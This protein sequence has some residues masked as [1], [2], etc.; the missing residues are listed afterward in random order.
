VQTALVGVYPNPFNPAAV[1]E[2]TVGTATGR[3]TGGQQHA[4]EVRVAVYDVLGRE[5]ATLVNG[6]L[7]PGR[8][9]VSFDGRAASSGV[10]F[11]R[12][13]AGEHTASARMLLVR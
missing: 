5:V 1:I 8:Y 11:C 2:F 13:T 9:R 4:Q 12:F 7:V 6:P 3:G 10:Y